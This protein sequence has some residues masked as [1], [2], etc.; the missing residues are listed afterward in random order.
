MKKTIRNLLAATIAS[1]MLMGC[2]QTSPDHVHTFASE[3]SHDET[4][5]WHAATCGHDVKDAT[6]AHTFGD[7]EIVTPATETATGLKKHTCSVCDYEATETIPVLE[8]VHT[9][10]T[11]TWESDANTHWHPATCGHDVKGEE[12]PHEFSD[13]WIVETDVTDT[14]DG[15]EMRKCTV[16]DYKIERPLYRVGLD[17]AY[18]FASTGAFTVT[19]GVDGV[20]ITASAMG[21]S[22][23]GYDGF[24]LPM[25]GIKV[26]LVEAY[27]FVIKNN[28]SERGE[29][30]IA[31]RDTSVNPRTF[32]NSQLLEDYKIE[33]LNGRSNTKLRE[34]KDGF[35]KF[36]IEAG[37]TA[38]ITVPM[39]SEAYDQFVL[40][41]VH[42]TMDV[43]ATIIQTG[44]IV[45]QHNF[46]EGYHHD[47]NYHWHECSD[48]GCDAIKGKAPHNWV[49]DE[50]KTDVAPTETESGI[51]YKVCSVCGA[52]KEVV[53]PPTS[54][55]STELF[56]VENIDEVNGGVTVADEDATAHGDGVKFTSK[57]AIDQ[58]T[59]IF[60]LVLTDTP[61]SLSASKS[62]EAK[63]SFYLN[64]GGMSHATSQSELKKC[65]TYQLC[66]G[67]SSSAN[68]A[69][70]EGR[71]D[72]TGCSATMLENDWLKI[73][74]DLAVFAAI[75]GGPDNFD[76]I[77]FKINT[78]ARLAFTESGQTLIMAG[79]ESSGFV[80]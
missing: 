13:E 76:R 11:T 70:E 63:F 17:V 28:N 9:F 4:S 25:T 52:T 78:P 65:F 12:A 50:S 5:H 75:S 21:D 74:M 2:N 77:S 30:R 44:A 26:E 16:C 31:Y 79:F 35:I 47:E 46:E 55:E 57:G 69:S 38:K 73:E 61:Y 10:D 34:W 3:W 8:H 41:L 43:N 29:Y 80:A 66:N 27:T 6:A 62:N 33:S 42:S 45:G 64:Y 32:A 49:S 51:A 59:R 54:Q 7:W 23:Q 56:R 15:V 14:E 1:F 40:M 68:R 48:E 72:A 18:P 39:V 58:Y 67:D 20:T 60:S 53:L 36:N 19:S 37:D 22:S 71:A 24:Y